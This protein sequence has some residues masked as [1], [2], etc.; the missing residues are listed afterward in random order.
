MISR[1]IETKLTLG[2]KRRFVLG[3]GEATSITHLKDLY[4]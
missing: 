3:Y 4:R 2:K 1:E